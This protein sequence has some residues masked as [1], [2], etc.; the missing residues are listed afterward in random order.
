MEEGGP[1]FLCKLLCCGSCCREFESSSDERAPLIMPAGSARSRRPSHN[2]SGLEQ[3]S[4]RIIIRRVG[5][6]DLD[7]R[8]EEFAET[9]NKQH[10]HYECMEEKR[11]TL[12][13]RYRCSSGDSLS[14]CLKKIKDE[15]DS[16]HV[17][18]QMKGYDFTLVVTPETEIPDKLKRTQENITE[19]CQAAK[20][21]VAVGTKL[22]ELISWLL[23]AE[24]TLKQQVKEK[25]GSHQ[26]QRRLAGNLQQNLQEARRAKDL[27]PRYREEAGKLL[28]EAALLSGVTP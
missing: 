24:E 11:N 14:Q 22:Q 8:F 15:H 10:E 20:A 23:K 6:P 4:G 13:F 2:G 1:G 19:L 9:F 3:R 17:H 21:V 27:S 28:N 5:V 25:A 16:H 12:V 7:Q 18:L 26:E